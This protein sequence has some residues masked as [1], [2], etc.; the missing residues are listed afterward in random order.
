MISAFMAR[1]CRF[2]DVIQMERRPLGVP[3]GN[4]ACDPGMVPG[5]LLDQ[6][7]ALRRRRH[8]PG[9][10]YHAAAR[11][12][13]NVASLRGRAQGARQ[14]KP[15]PRHSPMDEIPPPSGGMLPSDSGVGPPMD[16]VPPPRD[17]TIPP[18]R[19]GTIPPPRGG[20][21]PPPMGDAIPPPMGDAIPPPMGDTPV[22]GE[23]EIGLPIVTPTEMPPSSTAPTIA[24]ARRDRAGGVG[25]PLQWLPDSRSRRQDAPDQAH[26]AHRQAILV[27]Q[28][29]AERGRPRRQR[30]ERAVRSQRQLGAG[31]PLVPEAAQPALARLTYRREQDDVIAG[32]VRGCGAPAGAGRQPAIQ[33]APDD[34]LEAVAGDARSENAAGAQLERAIL[35]DD[36]LLAE[37]QSDE[38]RY[39]R[40]TVAEI[41]QLQRDLILPGRAALK[42]GIAQCEAAEI[43]AGSQ[44]AGGPRRQ[45][46]RLDFTTKGHDG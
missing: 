12:A 29:D 39:R 22:A 34:E 14:D 26:R 37:A 13:R 40:R 4:G 38:E 3:G 46:L 42:R 27:E 15:L 44:A 45:V 32:Q 1:P 5:A 35:S 10:R 8:R 28:I 36:L 41:V 17:G 24:I 2:L 9:G 21:I 30:Q 25:E 19:G 33:G 7:E 20:T 43:A 11:L 23:P 18:P 16:E 31:E 6:C